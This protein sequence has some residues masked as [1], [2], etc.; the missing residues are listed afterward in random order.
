MCLAGES[1]E[2]TG[3]LPSRMAAL[4]FQFDVYSNA[5]R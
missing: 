4:A 1:P 3:M 5:C 2:W